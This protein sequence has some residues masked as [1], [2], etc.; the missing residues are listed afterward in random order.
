MPFAGLPATSSCSLKT[1]G[2]ASPSRR[3]F[4]RRRTQCS[5]TYASVGGLDERARS[6]VLINVYGPPLFSFPSSLFSSLLI[7]SSATE[8]PPPPFLT[9]DRRL[10][11]IAASGR[12][13]EDAEVA[14]T[15]VRQRGRWSWVV[16]EGGHAV[17]RFAATF[18]R[19]SQRMS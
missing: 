7:A 1:D 17:R 14:Q 15:P 3:P 5:T 16:R 10:F 8:L 2:I 19:S 18:L 13:D 11:L 9:L 12:S 4:L 6:S